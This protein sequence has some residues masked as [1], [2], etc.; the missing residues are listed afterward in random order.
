MHGTKSCTLI[1]DHFPDTLEFQ[2]GRIYD[3]SRKCVVYYLDDEWILQVMLKTCCT[4]IM[5]KLSSL[6]KFFCEIKTDVPFRILK[7]LWNFLLLYKTVPEEHARLFETFYSNS[8]VVIGNRCYAIP[9]NFPVNFASID[10][11]CS[12]LQTLIPSEIESK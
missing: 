10:D 3:S 4:D 1:V 8:K 6:S 7:S 11:L 2:G 5:Y 12:F 9:D